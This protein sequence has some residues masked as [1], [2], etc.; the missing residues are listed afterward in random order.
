MS[1]VLKDVDH[2]PGMAVTEY[3]G[4]TQKRAI[5]RSGIHGW[6]NGNAG[7]EFGSDFFN[8]LYD[9]G[10]DRR[11]WARRVRRDLRHRDLVIRKHSHEC[12]LYFLH[13]LPGQHAAV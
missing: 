13:W 6:H 9:L 12:L 8:C 10:L 7:P 1:A 5:R 4:V 11:R 2:Q 3:A